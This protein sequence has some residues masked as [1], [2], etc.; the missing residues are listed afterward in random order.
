MLFTNLG[1]F[2][3]RRRR[4]VLAF[5][6]LF[7]VVAGA[8]GSGA[9]GKLKPGGFDDPGAE[10]TRARQVLEQ[11]FHAGDPNVVLLVRAT[12]GTVDDPAAVA[13]AQQ[14]TAEVAATPGATNVV[15]YWSLGNAAPL[16]STD[17]R[18]AVVVARIEGTDAE[19]ADR[20]DDL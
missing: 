3:V 6:V 5:T 7:L 14:V 17:R 1:R 12:T 13:A 10:S 15:S 20:F 9:F 8:L 4:L 18:A 19:I 2:T 11:Q 16:R